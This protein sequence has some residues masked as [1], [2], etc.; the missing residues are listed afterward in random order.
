MSAERVRLG[1]V[2]LGQWGRHHAR[3]FA[4]MP[5]V[6]LV[7]VVDRDPREVGPAAARYHTRGYVDHRDLIGRVDAVS[8][9]VPTIHHFAVAQDFLGAGVHVLLEKPMTA[10]VEEA[11]RLVDLS[12]RRGVVMLVGHVER[13]KPAVQYLRDVVAEPL[14]IHARRVRPFEPNRVTDVGVVLDLMIHDLD[15]VLSLVPERVAEIGG[16][17]VRVHNSHEDLAV[18]HLVM[19]GGCRMTLTASRVSAVKAVE[20][21]VTMADR[22]VHL[23]YLH[24]VVSIRHFNG[25][26]QRIALDGEEPLR[27]ELS[28]FVACVR[29]EERPRVS[30]EDGYRALE[31]SHRLLARMVD[32]TPRV[33]A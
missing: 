16:V 21:E 7:G 19:E 10:T 1:V 29:G 28:H 24:E 25:A 14:Y 11:Q 20:M 33:P 30:A 17:G 2:G 31:V 13:F 8:V 4:S 27:A 9:V 22:T 5:E 18:A 12:R 6:D 32:I 23:D 3:V 15:I 26:Y